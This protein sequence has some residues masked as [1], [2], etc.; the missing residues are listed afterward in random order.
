MR[1]TA[2]LLSLALGGAHAACTSPTHCSLNGVCAAGVCICNAGWAGPACAALDIL[3]V[4]TS[5]GRNQLASGS[6]SWGGAALLVDGMYHAY[7]SVM[8]GANCTLSTWESHSTCVHGTAASPLGPFAD[9]DVVMSAFCHN[10]LPARAPDGTYLIY[11]IGCGGA[12]SPPS[13]NA[14]A[15]ATATASCPGGNLAP[16]ILYAPTPSGPW[17]PL[18]GG[19]SILNGTAGAWDESVTNVSPWFMPN[20][21]VLLA[22]RGKDAAKHELLGVASA[23]SWKG[24]YAKSVPG[25]ILAAVPGEDPTPFVDARGNAHILFHDFSSVNGGHAFATAWEGPWSYTAVP[26][27]NRSVPLVDGSVLQLA[28]RERPLLYFDPATGAP[29]VLY[30]GVVTAADAALAASFTMAAEIRG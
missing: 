13:C 8:A 28:R 6:S 17:T 26:A 9:A 7:Y 5:H 21:T 23:P 18:D 30:T 16:R 3:P 12:P 14:G 11:H 1:V 27:Y 24:P 2:L 25:P 29:R 22:F 20:G 15:A 4:N 10:T 19:A